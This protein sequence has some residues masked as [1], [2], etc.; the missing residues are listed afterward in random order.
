[1]LLPK[2]S[3]YDEVWMQYEENVRLIQELNMHSGD[4]VIDLI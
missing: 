2:Y 1:M 3:F 4:L